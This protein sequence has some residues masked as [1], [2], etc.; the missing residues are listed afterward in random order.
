[1]NTEFKDLIGLLFT[2]KHN[3]IYDPEFQ[4]HLKKAPWEK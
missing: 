3:A 2:K 4:E 1:M